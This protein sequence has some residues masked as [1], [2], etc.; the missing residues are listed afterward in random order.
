M[1]TF[2]D[3]RNRLLAR[4]AETP[5]TEFLRQDSL[6]IGFQ[7][8]GAK[9]RVKAESGVDDLFGDSVF[10]HEGALRNVAEKPTRTFLQ[11]I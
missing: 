1:R 11:V 7:Q 8:G 10:G 5:A 3:H 4:R 9:R 2:S 6:I